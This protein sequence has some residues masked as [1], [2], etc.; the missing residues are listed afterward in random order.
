MF[1]MTRA[2]TGGPSV[3][4]NFIGLVEGGIQSS[5]H[6]FSSTPIGDASSGR[7]VVVCAVASNNGLTSGSCTVAG[8]AMTR[9]AE[10]T[11]SNRACAIFVSNSAVTSGTTADIVLTIG[12]SADVEIYVYTLE[13]A[14]TPTSPD[15]TVTDTSDPLSVSVNVPVGGAALAVACLEGNSSITWVGLTERDESTSTNFD[16]GSAGDEI[17]GGDAS[18]TVSVSNSGIA[19]SLCVAAWGL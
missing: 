19:R 11:N 14:G 8:G 6:T 15:D 9:V 12:A 1:I 5:P 2:A 10:A 4:L 3:S 18:L 7:Y 17:S 16:A 13:Y